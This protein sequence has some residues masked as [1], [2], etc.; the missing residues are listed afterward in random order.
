MLSAF[1]QT[2][3][4]LCLAAVPVFRLWLRKN[5]LIAGTHYTIHR[6]ALMGKAL[7]DQLKNVLGDVVKAVNFVKANAFNS[8][9][10]AELC[11]ESDYEFVALLLHSHVRWQ[12]KGKV[13]KR[14]LFCGEKSKILCKAQNQNCT[15]NFLMIV[16]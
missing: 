8:R 3:L 11:N 2:V 7:P 5:L 4:Q 12:S 10:F 15:R 16:F 1:A 6:Q 9:L 14:V 13:L